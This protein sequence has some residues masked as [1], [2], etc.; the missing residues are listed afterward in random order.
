M[1]MMMTDDEYYVVQIETQQKD[2]LRY[3]YHR[4][5]CKIRHSIKFPVP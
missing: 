5:H 1:M 3:N 2:I 4:C